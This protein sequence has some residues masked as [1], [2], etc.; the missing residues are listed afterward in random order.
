MSQPF[1]DTTTLRLT[2]PL[3][4]IVDEGAETV[5]FE[6]QLGSVI[7]IIEGAETPCEISQANFAAHEWGYGA[8]MPKTA[9]HRIA[10]CNIFIVFDYENP[11]QLMS[12]IRPDNE[13]RS[14][15]RRFEVDSCVGKT[16]TAANSSA[17]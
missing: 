2:A 16:S 9:L 12:Q 15:N 6:L 11:R 14:G 3:L 1:T 17:F 7:K 4:N 13:Q 10:L 8:A 5:L